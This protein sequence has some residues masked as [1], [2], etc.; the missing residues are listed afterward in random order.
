MKDEI[1]NGYSQHMTPTHLLE[2]FDRTAH[3]CRRSRMRN[4]DDREEESSR[5]DDEEVA[6]LTYSND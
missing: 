3:R 2:K 1:V 4:D 5:H 6:L